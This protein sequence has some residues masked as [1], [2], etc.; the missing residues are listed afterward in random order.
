MHTPLR[1]NQR[2]EG[3]SV[4]L[5]PEPIS[6]ARVAVTGYSACGVADNASQKFSTAIFHKPLNLVLK[7]YC[8][9]D[10]IA[11]ANNTKRRRREAAANPIKHAGRTL[12]SHRPSSALPAVAICPI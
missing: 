5:L 4:L 7:Y 6:G 8:T 1:R 11:I 12:A 9:L 2:T 3:A 10:L